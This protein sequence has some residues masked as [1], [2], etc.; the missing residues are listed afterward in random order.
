MSPSYRMSPRDASK[1]PYSG[2]PDMVPLT[3]YD[4]LFPR[5]AVERQLR[6]DG[7]CIVQRRPSVFTVNALMCLG[8]KCT[9]PAVMAGPGSAQ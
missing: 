6:N 2:E 7:L 3:H 9:S 4:T 1:P 8:K 5:C